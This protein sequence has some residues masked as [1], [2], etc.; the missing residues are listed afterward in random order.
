MSDPWCWASKRALQLIR[1]NCKNCGT[2]LAV[3]HALTEIDSDNGSTG[4]VE[5]SHKGISLRAA[6]SVRT[7]L[8]RLKDLERCGAIKIETPALK[9]PCKYTLNMIGNGCATFGN[10]CRTLRTESVN[11]LHSTNIKKQ[12]TRMDGY[13]SCDR[14]HTAQPQKLSTPDRIGL[15]KK[16]EILRRREEE[17]S[18][19]IPDHLDRREHPEKVQAL[20]ALK[21]QRKGLEDQLLANQ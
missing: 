9:A 15:E 8:Q 20:K 11:L 6:F 10:G 21:A 4:V 7:V 2:A 3:Y 12:E 14:T 17:L 5:V 16:L 19:E 1:D 13:A 18:A